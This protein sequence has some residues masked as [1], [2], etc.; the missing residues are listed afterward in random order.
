M[1]QPIPIFDSKDNHKLKSRI[2][3]FNHDDKK[4]RA[5]LLERL[6]NSFL[7]KKIEASKPEATST[8]KEGLKMLRL[9]KT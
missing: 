9:F 5:D 4:E 3:I 1:Q 8:E 6:K 7:E 2:I